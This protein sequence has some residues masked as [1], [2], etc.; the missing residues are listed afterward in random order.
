M[1][2]NS[3]KFYLDC[4]IIGAA[5]FSM[6][7]GAGNMIFPPFLGFNGGTSWALSFTSYFLADIGLA[8]LTMF[9]MI[10]K[11]GPEGIVEPMGEKVGNIVLGVIAL[12]IGLVIAIPRTAAT[13]YELSIAPLFENIPLWVACVVFFSIVL[14]L[15]LSESGV[16]DIVGKILTPILFVGLLGMILLGV[17][18]PIGPIAAP[19]D[20]SAVITTGIESGYQTMDVLG[21]IVLGSLV[22]NSAADKGY[23]SVSA[24]AKASAMASLVASVGLFI[25]YFGLTYLGATA[26]TLYPADINHTN[27]MNNIIVALLPGNVGKIFFGVVVGLAC[28]TTAI[29][30]TSATSSFF[31]HVFKGRVPYRYIMSLVC[32]ASTAIA[33]V[34]IDNI[35]SIAG[36]ILGVI[37][38]PIL[39]L[40]ILSFFDKH[41]SKW[42]FRFAAYT[43]LIFS[44]LELAAVIPGVLGVMPFAALGFGWLLPAAVACALGEVCYRAFGRK[45][46]KA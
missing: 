37:Y 24:Q 36:S 28:L 35:I 5:L 18:S 27:L 40:V 22:L 34:G 26:S 2:K 33:C 10:R 16:V 25:V 29:A 11:Q 19:A 17:I 42:A 3:K 46:V 21:A 4:A 15:C 41:L 23:S 13:T 20:P 44:V 43:A 6:F 8:M 39:V 14:M 31:A 30:L 38:P 1:K 12:C 45:S 7:F 9:A 32:V